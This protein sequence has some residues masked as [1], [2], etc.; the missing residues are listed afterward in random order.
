MHRDAENI[1]NV[2]IRDSQQPVCQ[3][4]TKSAQRGEEGAPWGTE[5]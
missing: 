5:I 4:R 3:I 2:K 1:I